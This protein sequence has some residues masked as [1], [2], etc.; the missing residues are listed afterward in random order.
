MWG[1]RHGFGTLI[2]RL[3]HLHVV[4]WQLA[5][6]VR[7]CR[8]DLRKT[9][10]TLKT[11]M[12]HSRRNVFPANGAAHTAPSQSTIPSL[13][14]CNIASFF[15]ID[16]VNGRQLFTVRTLGGEMGALTQTTDKSTT[17]GGF[18]RFGLLGRFSLGSASAPSRVPLQI[19]S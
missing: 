7:R 14:R 16:V 15:R 1:D 13:S 6:L 11:R 4:L 8:L 10:K 3:L 17:S 2:R 18:G 12:R 9:L 19:S 5:R